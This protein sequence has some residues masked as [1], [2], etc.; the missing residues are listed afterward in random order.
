MG[1]GVVMAGK[2]LRMKWVVRGRG[3]A[4]WGWG[5]GVMVCGRRGG[6]GDMLR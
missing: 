1:V 4:G 3:G 5:G 2:R 6:E